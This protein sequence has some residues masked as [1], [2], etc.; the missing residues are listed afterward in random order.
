M[1]LLCIIFQGDGM[2]KILIV[3]RNFYDPNNANANCITKVID[4]LKERGHNIFILTW[5]YGKAVKPMDVFI[6]NI[7]SKL[8]YM[9]DAKLKG[10]KDFTLCQRYIIL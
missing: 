2:S 7:F 8:H 9:I 1:D 10:F 6:Q 4:C 3:C 5:E